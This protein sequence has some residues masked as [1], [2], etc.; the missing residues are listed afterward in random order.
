MISR[1]LARLPAQTWM[2]EG[3]L[4][5]LR[6]RTDALTRWVRAGRREDLTG[7]QAALGPLARLLLLGLL[8][9]VLWAIVRAL[10]WLLWLLG[11]LWLHA[12]RR[13]ARTRPADPTEAPPEAPS[14]DASVA[15]SGEALRALLLEL[16]EG[17]SAV[18]LRTVLAHLQQHPETA[19]LTARWRIA[20]LRA[21]L[22]A[23]DIPVHPKVKARGGGP[24]RGVRREDLAPSPAGPQEASIAP[25]TAV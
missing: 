6:R 21:R 3:S 17:G 2:Y 4:L 8:A 1:L 12:A 18:H 15:P 23:Q 22:E 9:Y 19:A 16:M 5:I 13:A 14:G 7:W 25:S 20:D 24:T 10:P 11:A